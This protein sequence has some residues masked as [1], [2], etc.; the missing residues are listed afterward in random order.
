M[1]EEAARVKQAHLAEL[2]DLNVRH[3][4]EKSALNQR[5]QQRELALAAE[6]EV[7]VRS[8]AD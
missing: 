1:H 4:G 5:L 6:I 2:S 7:L 3:N 8:H